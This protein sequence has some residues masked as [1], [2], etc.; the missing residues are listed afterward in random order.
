MWYDNVRKKRKAAIFRGFSL[1]FTLYFTQMLCYTSFVK[2][3][4]ELLN[5]IPCDDIESL[6]SAACEEQEDVE[7]VLFENL[8]LEGGAYPAMTFRHCRFVGCRLS[9]CSLE[10]AAFIDCIF[11]HCDL[12]N[13]LMPKGTMQRT[14][15]T[16]CKLLGVTLSESFLLDA[17]FE[18]CVAR[19]GNFSSSKLRHVRFLACDFTSAAIA[20]C[21]LSSTEFDDCLLTRTE[22]FQT[23]FSG[24]NLSNCD[25]SGISISGGELR[26]A[27]VNMEQAAMLGQLLAGVTIQEL[28]IKS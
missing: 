26:G 17:S 20:G 9:G 21:A 1:F 23:A 18:R 24:M 4:P 11:E 14:W 7:R 22:L 2:K 8:A 15:L 6:F 27:Y 25:L 5:L 12:S 28:P 10:R 16:D 13:T 3:Q 19:Y